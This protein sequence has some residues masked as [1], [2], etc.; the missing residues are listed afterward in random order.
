[1]SMTKRQHRIALLSAANRRR[2]LEKKLRP[3]GGSFMDAIYNETI[4]ATIAMTRYETA[5]IFK[6]AEYTQPP[7]TVRPLP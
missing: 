1:M 2:Q 5:F 7:V 3:R 6:P 4:H